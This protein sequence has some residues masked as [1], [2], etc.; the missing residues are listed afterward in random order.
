MAA[1]RAATCA[2]SS[3]RVTCW[4][5]LP[6]DQ[7]SPALV[8]ASASNPSDASSF[9]EPTSHGFGI[10]NSCSALVQRPEVHFRSATICATSVGVVPTCTPHASSASFLACAVPDEPEMIAPA[11][12]MVFPGGAEKPAM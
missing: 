7:A 4:S 5:S 3:S 10:T 8:V 12:P 1:A 9:A 6:S 11:W 2:T